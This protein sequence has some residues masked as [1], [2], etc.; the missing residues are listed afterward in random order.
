MQIYLD[1]TICDPYFFNLD[2]QE[3]NNEKYFHK[4]IPK[5]NLNTGTKT[6]PQGPYL[7]VKLQYV[8]LI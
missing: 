4:A 5:K 7:Y 1:W 8:N 2:V 3:T 6:K